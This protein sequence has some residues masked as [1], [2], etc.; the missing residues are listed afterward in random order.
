MTVGEQVVRAAVYRAFDA[1]DATVGAAFESEERSAY[2]VAVADVVRLHRLAPLV[3][4]A[5][6]IET[7]GQFDGDRQTRRRLI[8]TLVEP[9]LA[10]TRAHVDDAYALLRE[11]SDLLE[12]YVEP[13]CAA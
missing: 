6:A 1:R 12:P 7:A 10:E 8:A 11:S 4:Y 5:R 13:R 2:L 3:D 9:D